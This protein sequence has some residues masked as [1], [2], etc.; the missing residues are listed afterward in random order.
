MRTSTA[1]AGLLVGLATQAGASALASE[2]TVKV[3][4]VDS[5]RGEIGCALFES[6][7]GFPTDNSGAR[8]IWRPTRNGGAVCRFTDVPAGRVAVAVSHDLNK[9]RVTDTNFLGIPTEAWGVSNNVRPT[10]RAPR[11]DEAAFDLKAGEKAS[12]EIEVLK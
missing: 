8:S 4:G 9:N 10:L 12:I 6:A 5:D 7:D 3:S 11:F 1:V 2:L